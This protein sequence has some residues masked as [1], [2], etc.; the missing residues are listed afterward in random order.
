MTMMQR[1]CLLLV[2]QIPSKLDRLSEDHDLLSSSNTEL[3]QSKNMINKQ[4]K[5][6]AIM[7][8]TCRGH[9]LSPQII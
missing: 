6:S 9:H 2:M 5:L 7:T 3:L 4:V 1:L 8:K